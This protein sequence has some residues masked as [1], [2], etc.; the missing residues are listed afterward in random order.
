M[1]ERHPPPA[2]SLVWEPPADEGPRSTASY[3]AGAMSSLALAP[4]SAVAYSARAVGLLGGEE[5]MAHLG[6]E[7]LKLL[8]VLVHHAPWGGKGNPF[9][10]ALGRLGDAE[11]GDGAAASAAE[12]G[13]AAGEGRGGPRVPFRGLFEAVCQH[14]DTELATLLLYSLLHGSRMFAD[15]VT[16][17]GE[18]AG[19]MTPLLHSLYAIASKSTSQLYL[20]LIILLML[21]Q[22]QA[23]T[24]A[25]HA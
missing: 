2:G 23:L 14:M 25:L 11:G 15:F 16:R 24:R 9:R 21:T 17:S 13:A 4:L 22:N 19:L 18:V 3:V 10:L 1:V 5:G 20:L 12:M 8:L 6:T 7:S